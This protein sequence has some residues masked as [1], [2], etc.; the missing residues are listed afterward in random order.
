[1]LPEIREINFYAG[2]FFSA[3]ISH[4]HTALCIL[5]L[6]PPPGFRGYFQRNVIFRYEICKNKTAY[7]KQTDEQIRWHSAGPPPLPSKCQ[8]QFQVKPRV[9]TRY[10]GCSER[11]LMSDES[12]PAS[13][14]SVINTRD[15][16][17]PG[18]LSRGCP[19]TT[20]RGLV[21]GRRR[22]YVGLGGFNQWFM[23]NGLSSL[24]K[25]KIYRKPMT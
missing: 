19:N 18:H 2:P 12:P 21:R 5:W 3:H 8:S 25:E 13:L 1:M 16:P 10:P 7:F 22:W 20:S 4:P 9:W 11:C 17:W 15:G 6:I 14:Y 24:L 23:M